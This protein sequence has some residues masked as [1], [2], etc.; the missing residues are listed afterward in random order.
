MKLKNK[1]VTGLCW[2]RILNRYL[3]LFSLVFLLYLPSIRN[4]FVYDD[5][6]LILQK[7]VPILSV[8]TQSHWPDLTV[9]YYRPV[10][11]LT[12]VVQKWLHGDN[13]WPYHLFNNFLAGIM[14]CWVYAILR[15]PLFTIPNGLAW[16][17]ALLFAVHPI[18]ASCVYPICSGRETLLPVLFI[19]AAVYAW[20]N[21]AYFFCLA[22]FVLALLSKE[23][24]LI[25]PLIFWL[26]DH[27]KERIHRRPYLPVMIIVLVYFLIRQLIFKGQEHYQ[28]AIFNDPWGPFLTIIYTLQTILTPF[29]ELYYEPWVAVWFSG[30]RTLICLSIIL[31]MI[32]LFIKNKHKKLILFWSAWFLTGMLMTANLLVQ[33]A[34]FAERYGLFS[35]VGLIG[36][37]LTLVNA[38]KILWGAILAS[39]VISIHR[40]EYFKNDLVFQKQWLQTSPKFHILRSC[41]QLA[42]FENKY[43]VQMPWEQGKNQNMTPHWKKAVRH[44]R[45]ALQDAPDNLNLLQ[46]LARLYLHLKKY[47]LCIPV[48]KTLLEQTADPVFYSYLACACARNNETDQAVVWLQEGFKH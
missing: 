21:S 14:A 6:A 43:S 19:L 20:I 39:A 17:G 36:M 4:G 27:L 2:H 13:P 11:R 34:R 8:F 7:S 38:R 16:G 47:D 35:M 41:Y 30:Q 24:A 44:Y 3:W 18:T 23:L 40:A 37:L 1:A 25:T 28:I 31:I 46:R 22:M 29:M 45:I 32:C 10:A 15:L 42:V 12:M 9:T 26:T 33:E 48:F 5:H